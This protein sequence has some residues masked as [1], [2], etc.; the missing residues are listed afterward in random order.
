MTKVMPFLIGAVV[1]LIAYKFL[2][3]NIKTMFGKE[4]ATEPL[5]KYAAS[6]YLLNKPTNS[7]PTS[8]TN[9]TA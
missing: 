5:G 7:A 3:D 9:Q 4:E 1:A 2:P 6:A 8:S